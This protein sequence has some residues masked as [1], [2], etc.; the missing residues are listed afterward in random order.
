MCGYPLDKLTVQ[1]WL[2]Y[3]HVNL[4]YCTFNVNGTELRTN[5]RTDRRTIQTQDAPGFLNR[6]HKNQASVCL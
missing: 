4:K 2:M 5:R 1:V 6:G 3:E